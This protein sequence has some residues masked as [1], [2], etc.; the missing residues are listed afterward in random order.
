MVNKTDATKMTNKQFLEFRANEFK[1][2]AKAREE[3]Q[4]RKEEG[5]PSLTFSL[6]ESFRKAGL[7]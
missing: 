3:E 4:R 5:L 7:V 1:R 2:N 6:A